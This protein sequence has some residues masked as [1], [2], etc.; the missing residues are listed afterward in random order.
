MSF[1]GFVNGNTFNAQVSGVRVFVYADDNG[2]PAGFPGDGLDL[3]VFSLDI[4]NPDP[5][6][7]VDGGVAGTQVN[8]DV[9]AANGGTAPELPA[10]TYWAVLVVDQVS[11]IA[12]SSFF[13]LLGGEDTDDSA[14][15]FA[16]AVGPLFGLPEWAV[17]STD[18]L[19][20]PNPAFEK[21]SFSVSG[22]GTCG[23]SWITTSPSTGTV[24]SSGSEDVVVTLD[25]TGVAEGTYNATLCIDN[26]DFDKSQVLVPV[27]LTV[28]PSDLIF[29]NGFEAPPAP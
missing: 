23:A 3:E 14:G 6:L 20:N 4:P 29:E 21:M 19:T 5:S 18:V 8:I 11:A 12:D 13:W 1:D 10:G 22:S 9:T 27:T 15:S 25:S 16:H 28:G 7:V 17:L 24:G 26:D 2:T